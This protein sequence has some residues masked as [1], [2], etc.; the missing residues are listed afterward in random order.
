MA[1]RKTLIF[2]DDFKGRKEMGEAIDRL[3]NQGWEL[4]S[5]ETTQQGWAFGKTCCFGCLF[6]PLALLGKKANV[7]QVIMKRE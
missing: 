5:K 6:L 3:S 4:E 2:Q 7:I 1:E